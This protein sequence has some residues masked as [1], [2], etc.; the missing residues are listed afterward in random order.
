ML[1]L[2]IVALILANIAIQYGINRW[3]RYFFD[4]LD[5]RETAKI[6]FAMP[7]FAGLAVSAI[8][9]MVAQVY[10]RLTLQARWRRWLTAS[11]AADWLQDRRFYQMNIAAPD[12]D[13]PE[14]RMTDDVRI[15]T[16]PIVDFAIGLSNAIL[17]AAVFVGVLWS[18]GGSLT[19][20]ALPFPAISWFAPVSM[21]VH[22]RHHGFPGPPA[23]PLHRTQERGR[24]AGPLR[25]RSRA[26]ECRE[27]RADWRGGRRGPPRQHL[28][29]RRLGT[30]EE[31]CFAAIA[32]DVHHSR[33]HHS[34]PGRAPAARCAEISVR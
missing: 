24:G 23:D 29:G 25:T 8:V 7:L 21:A 34:R 13:S 12:L 3:N 14:F 27:H 10:C 4:A 2:A 17:M 28:A 6:S 22:V 32:D 26:R 30:L 9:A 5:K 1:T 18:A 11:L 19:V 31:S 33:Q 20:W 15:A 16:E